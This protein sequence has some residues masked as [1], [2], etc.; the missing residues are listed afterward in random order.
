MGRWRTQL[1][2]RQL[3]NC[4]THEHRHFE[5]TL[6]STDTIPGP[7]LAE[8]RFKYN[9][10]TARACFLQGPRER[11]NERSCCVC[12]LARASFEM[13]FRIRTMGAQARVRCVSAPSPGALCFLKTRADR[14]VSRQTAGASI[15]SAFGAYCVKNLFC[16]RPQSRRDYPLNL[17]I[18]LSGGKETN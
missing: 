8:G 7:R 10:Q 18:L 2:A 17:S 1:I 6:R 16:W 11:I 9:K 4:R 5:R 13:K 12:L 3:V 14:C 15:A